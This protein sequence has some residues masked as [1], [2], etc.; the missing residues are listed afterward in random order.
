[1][2]PYADHIAPMATTPLNKALTSLSTRLEGINAPTREV[3]NPWTCP[4]E[5]L[6]SLAHAFSVDLWVDE[7][8]EIRKRRIIANAVEMHRQKGTLAAVLSYLPYVDASL[9]SYLVPPIKVFSGPS[10]TREQREAWLSGLPQIRT[11]RINEP[12]QRGFGLY[13]SGFGHSSFFERAFPVPSTA[14]K[15]LRRRARWV[16][17]GVETETRVSEFGSWFRLHLNG[18]EGTKVF[19]GRIRAKM[20]F[21]PSTARQRLVTIEPTPTAPW[22]SA[23]GPTLTPVT[24][25]P[26]RI[27][28]QGTRRRGVF[29]GAPLGAGY[30]RPSTAAYRIYWRFPVHDGSRVNRRPSIQFMGVGR[31][32]FPA[33]T[34]YLEIL[35]QAKRS[36]WSAGEGIHL[37]GTRFWTPHDPTPIANVRRA[38]MAAKRASDQILIK[39][40]E[41]DIDANG[42][43]IIAGA[44]GFV[45]L[46]N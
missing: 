26:E 22:R 20:F 28:E 30:F 33:H 7:W 32:G 36:R 45:G 5:F 12:G 39:Y 3:W 15:R 38:L 43:P 2:I 11:W 14:L 44:G 10:L 24:T 8:A 18:Q 46:P 13:S 23:V 17:D 21:Q 19:A 27:V 4:P 40:P 42:N 37:P 16:V 6:K 29:S 31:Y 35:V 1:M 25:E 34:A 9:K 41:R